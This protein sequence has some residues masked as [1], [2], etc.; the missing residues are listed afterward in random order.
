M[1]DLVLRLRQGARVAPGGKGRQRLQDMA[2]WC[3]RVRQSIDAA[4]R[5]RRSR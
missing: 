5:K 2:D 1:N 3:E 4:L